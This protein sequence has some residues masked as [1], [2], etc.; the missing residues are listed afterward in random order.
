MNVVI[1]TGRLSKRGNECYITDC[2]VPD[3]QTNG[4]YCKKY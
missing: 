4:W 2:G 3:I 1:L